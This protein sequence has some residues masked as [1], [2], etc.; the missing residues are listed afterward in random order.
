MNLLFLTIT[1]ITT[2]EERGIYTDLMRKFRDEGHNVYIACPTERKFKEPTRLL[3]SDRVQILNIWTLNAQKTSLFEKGVCTLLLDRQF[4]SAIQKYFQD[5]K[6]DLI[7]YATPPITFTDTIAW[8]K[9]RDGAVT[10]LLLKDIF[11]QNAAD[12]GMISQNGPIF[13]YF[14]AK[15]KKL[16]KVSDYIGCLSPANVDFLLR[17]NPDIDPAVVEVNPNTIEP[18][19]RFAT[20]EQKA[21]TRKKFS[22]PADALVFLYGGNLGKPQGIDFLIEVLE[23]N[24]YRQ[25]IFFIIVG[26]GTELPKL[27]NWFKQSEAKNVS[28]L[29]GLPKNEFDSLIAT[30]DIGLIFLD[31]R[32]TIPNFPSRL[33]SYLEN[34]MPVLAATDPNTDIG[35]IIEQA[36]C[37]F[38]VES[39]DLEGFN[40]RIQRIAA[41][42]A[43]MSSNSLRLL[44]EQYKVGTSYK[45]IMGRMAQK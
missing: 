7:L 15:E 45:L 6:F 12:L 31:K 16:Y 4:K 33:L 14:R 43:T 21:A 13:S 32:F 34:A 18:L 44:N 22:I 11:P 36:Q 39:G 3:K 24:K 5:I 20:A 25:G 42:A 2:L 28:V 26:S 27:M 29:E 17:H 1:R 10:Y 38:W 37:G 35:I 23:S 8:I 19:Q 40:E 30:C 9:R 41:E